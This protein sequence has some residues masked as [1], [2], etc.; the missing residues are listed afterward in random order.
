MRKIILLFVIDLLIT[1]CG[2]NEEPISNSDVQAYFCIPE[3]LESCLPLVIYNTSNGWFAH[4]GGSAT[5][6]SIELHL[7]K[8]NDDEVENGLALSFEEYVDNKLNGCYFFTDFGKMY[9]LKQGTNDTISFYCTHLYNTYILSREPKNADEEFYYDENFDYLECELDCQRAL[10]QAYSNPRRTLKN[11]MDFSDEENV[12]ECVASPDGKVRLT[13]IPYHTRG[14]GMGTNCEYTILQYKDGTGVSTLCGF[15]NPYYM[16]IMENKGFDMNFGHLKDYRIHLVRI[17]GIDYYLIESS[18]W[19]ECPISIVEGKDYYA[20]YWS[21]IS[22]YRIYNGKFCPAP[23]LGGKK[24]ICIKANDV[25]TDMHFIVDAQKR[26]IKVPRVSEKDY[27][28]SGEY[29]TVQLK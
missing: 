3:R 5:A 7:R 25:T 27:S 2:R 29:D 20:F 8:C 19:D 12:F 9:Y 10:L 4:Y 11:G 28:F 17:N 21:A 23:I 15:G 1:G 16:D 24:S 6:S 26:I 14:N 13:S 18:P 22:A